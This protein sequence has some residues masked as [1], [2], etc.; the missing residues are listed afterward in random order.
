[1]VIDTAASRDGED[2]RQLRIL[3]LGSIL[4]CFVS[5]FDLLNKLYTV[6]GWQLESKHLVNV[7]ETRR[8]TMERMFECP[9]QMRCTT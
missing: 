5:D 2:Y 8:D 4:L 3:K 9:N 6:V 1:M 7:P